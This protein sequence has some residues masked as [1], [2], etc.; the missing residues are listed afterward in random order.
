M[1]FGQICFDP[2]LRLSLSS[3]H[4]LS[5][6]SC[7]PLPGY[8]WLNLTPTVLKFLCHFCLMTFWLS[9]SLQRPISPI[10]ALILT[11][12]IASISTHLQSIR[13]A[14]VGHLYQILS[15]LDCCEVSP[16]FTSKYAG[17]KKLTTCNSLKLAKKYLLWLLQCLYILKNRTWEA[18]LQQSVLCTL[19]TFLVNVKSKFSPICY[20]FLRFNFLP[21][22]IHYHANY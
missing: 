22:K 7:L 17:V 3:V 8:H 11:L 15:N 1:I 5:W 13:E 19:F 6:S 2:Y 21:V 14:R 20:T 9:F 12:R 10:T 18:T 16:Q 4:L